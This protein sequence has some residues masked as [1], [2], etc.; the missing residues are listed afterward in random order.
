MKTCSQCRQTKPLD[1]FAVHVR[2]RLDGRQ[3]KCKRCV[4]DNASGVYKRDRASKMEANRV[5][6]L[7]K[8]AWVNEQKNVPCADCHGRFPAIC[9]DLDHV[10]GTKVMRVSQMVHHSWARLK[11]EVA[12]CEV[13]C[14][15]CHRVRTARRGGFALAV[16]TGA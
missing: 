11:A 2:N 16:E 12:K 7:R 14:A 10:S 13:V 3:P 6:R 1:S 5:I 15:N 4:A 8:Q 9:M